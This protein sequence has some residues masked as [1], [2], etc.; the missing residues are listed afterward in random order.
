VSVNVVQPAG[1]ATEGVEHDV[2]LLSSLTLESIADAALAEL[3]IARAE[4]EVVL[5]ELNRVAAD[6]TTLMTLPRIFQTW[7]WRVPASGSLG[8]F[9]NSEKHGGGRS[10]R[11]MLAR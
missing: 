9:G 7:G 1:R 3:A 11:G 6:P 4:L 2:K 10:G 5:D 8:S